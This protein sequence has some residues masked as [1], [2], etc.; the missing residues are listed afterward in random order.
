[1]VYDY[2]FDLYETKYFLKFYVR[3]FVCFIGFTLFSRLVRF[4]NG[5]KQALIG[6]LVSAI[7]L[8]MHLHVTSFSH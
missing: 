5:C 2:H 4:Y 1:M 3:W 7:L 6:L 8:H